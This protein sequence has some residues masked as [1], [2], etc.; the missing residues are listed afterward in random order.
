MEKLKEELSNTNFDPKTA[1]NWENDESIEELIINLKEMK[2]TLETD[3][4]ESISAYVLGRERIM[5]LIK[6]VIPE[7]E[8]NIRVDEPEH[9]LDSLLEV[10]QVK[11]R[12]DVCLAK[13][14]S[15]LE[16]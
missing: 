9:K 12:V 1:W 16:T 2:T 14:N 11:Q 7:L 5:R 13:L 3:I 10:V 8:L 15:I 4:T 6:E